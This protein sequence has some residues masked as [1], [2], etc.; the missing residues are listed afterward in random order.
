MD[1][2]TDQDPGKLISQAREIHSKV[3]T[4]E[5]SLLIRELL[6]KALEDPVR[7]DTRRLAEA[8]SLF[9]EILM[10]DYLNRW[11][12]AGAAEF[13][14]AEKA[15][16]RALEIVPDFA[17][18]HYSSGLVHR[19]K[20]EHGA[21]LAAFTR[22]VE[23]NPDFGLAHAQQGAQLIYTGRPLE[24]LPRIEQAIRISRADS[25]SRG[26][27]YWYMGRAQFTSC[28][29]GD[30]IQW[31]RQS[32]EARGNLWYNRLYLVSAYALT[33][34]S[35]AAAA[36]LDDF[37]NRFPNYSIA[38]V[39]QNEQASPHDHPVMVTSIERFHEGLR[40]AGMP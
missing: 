14:Q 35:A 13:A 19:A 33:H 16:R 30:S 31:L 20:G 17:P 38:H 36:A 3:L 5:N 37:N 9:A 40:L 23:L 39:V 22:T 1:N 6:Q 32:V 8:W 2:Q 4:P 18:A 28:N 10:C 27:Y 34:D 21:A 29:Y 7:I 25:T 15:V 24:A 12:D 26:M 11:N